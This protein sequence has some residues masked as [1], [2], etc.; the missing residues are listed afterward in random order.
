MTESKW[1][2]TSLGW[3]SSLLCSEWWYKL[4]NGTPP[5]YLPG[6]VQVCRLTYIFWAK[7]IRVVWV[8]QHEWKLGNH[9]LRVEGHLSSF[10]GSDREIQSHQPEFS[11]RSN[12]RKWRKKC[13]TTESQ[14]ESP[15]IFINSF[16]ALDWHMW[17]RGQE[18]F[19]KHQ[20]RG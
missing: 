10:P 19:K 8:E 12:S 13:Q 9:K 20:L 4:V 16:L 5:S 15:Q 3:R 14:E 2:W 7:T 18:T 1:N 17:R 11:E 6:Y